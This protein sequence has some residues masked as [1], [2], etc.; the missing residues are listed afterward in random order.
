M[1]FYIVS[2]SIILCVK[3]TVVIVIYYI[4]TDSEKWEIL[5]PDSW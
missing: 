5:L 3:T 2:W 4:V 1:L